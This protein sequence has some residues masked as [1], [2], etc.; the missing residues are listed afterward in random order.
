MGQ[1][2]GVRPLASTPRSNSTGLARGLTPSAPMI[3]M[4][5]Q[6]GGGAVELLSQDDAGEPVPQRDGPAGALDVHCLAHGPSQ[7]V[8]AAD[9]DGQAPGPALP[10]PADPPRQPLPCPPL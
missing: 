10:A 4:A 6:D 5:R 1:R 2:P 7:T 9:A 3:G 8:A